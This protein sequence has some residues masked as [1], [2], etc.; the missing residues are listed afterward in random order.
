MNRHLAEY[1]TEM[2]NNHENRKQEQ[3]IR[4]IM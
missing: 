1:E 4:A 2:A 3:E